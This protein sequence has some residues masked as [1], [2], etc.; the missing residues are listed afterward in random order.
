MKIHGNSSAEQAALQHTLS[1]FAHDMRGKG[2]GQR[3][4]PGG[5]CGTHPAQGR[6]YPFPMPGIMH[7]ARAFLAKPENLKALDADGDGKITRK[8]LVAVSTNKE[9]DNKMQRAAA[10][11]LK[12][13]RVFNAL[14]GSDGAISADDLK[15]PRPTRTTAPVPLPTK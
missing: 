12:H 1:V 13:E 10:Y 5:W 7:R 9:A 3:H 4:R 11:L 6:P 8:D 2:A 15:R 14:A